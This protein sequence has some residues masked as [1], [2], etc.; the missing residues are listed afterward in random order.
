M[1]I[2]PFG[3][4]VTGIIFVVCCLNCVAIWKSFHSSYYSRAQQWGHVG[5][6]LLVPVLGAF[7]TLYLSRQETPTAHSRPVD[8]LDG[9]DSTCSDFDYG[10]DH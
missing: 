1:Q 9:V 8:G 4:I 6:V 3:L 2:S 10:G 7:L 5:I